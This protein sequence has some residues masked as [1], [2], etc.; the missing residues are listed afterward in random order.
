MERENLEYLRDVVIPHCENME[1]I[2][3]WRERYSAAGG[4][5]TLTVASCA[6]FN[7]GT[8][9]ES[10]RATGKP[11]SKHYDCGLEGCLA[12]WYK[13]LSDRD[14]RD[15]E[16]LGNWDQDALAHHFG[17]SNASTSALFETRGAGAE[18]Q[19][20]SGYEAADT[21]KALQIRKSYLEAM[22]A[23]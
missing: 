21:M 18:R 8:Y 9:T 1:T 7:L 15:T 5:C 4:L 11:I 16:G 14:L 12:G 23:A 6:I 22:L 19:N 3:H 17:I 10:N 20:D 2:E 13:F